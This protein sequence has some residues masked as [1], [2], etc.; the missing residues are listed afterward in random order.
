MNNP[1]QG[2][3]QTQ[4]N[5]PMG[6]EQIFNQNPFFQNP[7]QFMQNARNNGA[8]IH[9]SFSN[10]TSNNFNVYNN[11][12]RQSP[13]F[14]TQQSYPS[15]YQNY[16]Q[17]NPSNYPRQSEY[18]HPNFESKPQT[19]DSDMK[20][21]A[22]KFNLQGNELYKRKQF[23]KALECYELGLD[24]QKH[25]KLYKNMAWCYKRLGL[26][27][28]SLKYIKKS[29]HLSPEDNV[30]F[31]LAGIFTFSLFTN[32]EK[33]NDGKQMQ[34]FFRRAYELEQNEINYF[35][36]ML[37]RK[38]VYLFNQIL[39]KEEKDELLNYLMDRKDSQSVSSSTE[40]TFK[41][42]KKELNQFL[43]P[44]F[45]EESPEIPEHLKGK[46]SLEI[47]KNPILTLSGISYERE[48]IIRYFN[49]QG[50][51]DPTTNEEFQTENC[52]IYNRHLK[53]HIKDFLR[54]NKWG[55]LGDEVI[56]DW[57]L[58]EFK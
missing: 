30:L 44:N 29:I 5:D 1:P 20:R 45:Y 40:D 33:L 54:K 27:K 39:Q 6:F 2:N 13:S 57:K 46:I 37:S 14:H 42:E 36:Y 26:F 11:H 51:K 25:W 22:L 28:E 52:L 15:N 7:E 4:P 31:R 47:M 53:K 49:E 32:S 24:I 12:P 43:K 8:H 9:T 55:F 10:N 17:T 56:K 34:E 21:N 35:N 16:Q 3:R 19:G 48:Y 41:E 38:V 23:R 58:F 50:W 18:S